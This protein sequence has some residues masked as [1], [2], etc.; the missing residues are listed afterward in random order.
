MHYVA[1]VIILIFLSLPMLTLILVVLWAFIRLLALGCVSLESLL[2]AATPDEYRR[3]AEEG[4][5]EEEMKLIERE[6]ENGNISLT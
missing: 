1:A 5:D 6:I 3:Q 2:E 4:P